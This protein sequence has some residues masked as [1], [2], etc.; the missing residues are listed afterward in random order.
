MPV[1]LN[2]SLILRAAAQRGKRQV[3]RTN[4]GFLF[5]EK[6]VFRPD[7]Q[8]RE[9]TLAWRQGGNRLYPAGYPA[10]YMVSE[11]ARM[12]ACGLFDAGAQ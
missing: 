4:G 8:A 2:V 6:E 9:A 11:T 12:F 5:A 3:Q 7:P 1:R 10:G